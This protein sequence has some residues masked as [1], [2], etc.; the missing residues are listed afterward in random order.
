MGLAL[1]R[2]ADGIFGRPHLPNVDAIILEYGKGNVS[3]SLFAKEGSRVCEFVGLWDGT[4]Y[5]HS[6]RTGSFATSLLPLI[7]SD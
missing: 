2:G 1:T 4:Q 6:N 7:F 3:I 5:V